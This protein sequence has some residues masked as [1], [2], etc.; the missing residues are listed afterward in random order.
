MI[1][2][3]CLS[4][5]ADPTSLAP[6][7]PSARI[8]AFGDS[9][10]RGTGAGAGQSYPEHLARLLSRD[11]VNAGV[12]GEV[13]AEGLRRLPDVL[14][15]EQPDLLLLCHGGN[16]ILRGLDKAQLQTNLQAMI[17][18]ARAQSIPVVLI[19]VPQRSLLLR[20]EPLYK[21]LAEEND[22]PL[23]DDVVADVLGESKWRSDRIHPNGKGYERI[24]LA[25]QTTLAEAGAL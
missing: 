11:V 12:P 20:A 14:A 9:L 7:A 10:T 24:A 13:S 1:L 4:G 18:M 2:L 15:A 21:A 23:L 6:L 3:L 19:A 22:V 5:C 16:D 17:D 25:V 8:L